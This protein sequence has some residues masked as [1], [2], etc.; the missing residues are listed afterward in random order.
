MHGPMAR[1]HDRYLDLFMRGGLPPVELDDALR[2]KAAEEPAIASG[3]DIKGLRAEALDRPRIEVI[4]VVMRDDD[5]I[6]RRQL[7]EREARRSEARHDT[8]ALPED[9]VDQ[10]ALAAERE[11]ERS[12][13]NP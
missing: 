1:R 13:A 12:V 5:H 10:K 9:R 8:E 4:A 11:E 2:A 7:R 3:R 6:N